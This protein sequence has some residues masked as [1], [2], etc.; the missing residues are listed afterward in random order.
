MQPRRYREVGT[1]APSQRTA[2]A[3]RCAAWLIKAVLGG[4][5]T[6]RYVDLNGGNTT[7]IEVIQSPN[8]CQCT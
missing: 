6:V 7:Q 4:S 2:F 1:F 3:G 5:D 8:S